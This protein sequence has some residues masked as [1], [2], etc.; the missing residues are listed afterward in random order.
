ME[1]FSR[2]LKG[3]EM[4]NAG[5]ISGWMLFKVILWCVQ[6]KILFPERDP[7]YKIN[8]INSLT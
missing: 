1:Q 6:R 2:S 5:G 3:E 4:K 8:L 7:V